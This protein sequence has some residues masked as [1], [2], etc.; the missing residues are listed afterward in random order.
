MVDI[1]AYIDLYNTGVS[2]SRVKLP[3]PDENY[4]IFKHSNV[5]IRIIDRDKNLGLLVQKDKFYSIEKFLGDTEETSHRYFYMIPLQTPIGTI[6]GFILRT[7][8]GKA[9]QTVCRDFPSRAEQVP[10]M[11]GWYKDFVDYN[12]EDKRLPIVICEGPKDCMVLKKIYKYTLSNN[13]SSLG[14]NLDVLRQITNDFVLVYDNDEPGL[15]GMEKDRNR[16]EQKLCYC[17]TYHVPDGYKDV[18]DLVHNKED[19]QYFARKLLTKIKKLEIK[20]I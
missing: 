5:D 10:I 7:V 14:T 11:Y 17:T 19:F 9:Y 20:A 12:K 2:L 15:R 6:V 16:L 4:F 18:S 13:T 3:N 1:N 8:Y